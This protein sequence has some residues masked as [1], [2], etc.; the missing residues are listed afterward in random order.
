MEKVEHNMVY[1]DYICESCGFTSQEQRGTY[2]CPVCGNKMKVH[3]TR[4]GGEFS[5]GTGKLLIYVLECIF[6]L[7]VLLIFLNI[8][9]LIIFIIILLLTRKHL[10]KNVQNKAIKT[11]PIRNPNKIYTCQTC[12]GNFKGQQPTCPHCGIRLTYNE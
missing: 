5:A 4:Y 12:G 1:E 3:Q 8:P 7:P 11:G 2:T 6:L 9:G 10:N